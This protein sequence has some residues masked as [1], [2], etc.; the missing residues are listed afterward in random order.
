MT[1]RTAS[2]ERKKKET[3]IKLSLS[4]DGTG[5]SD[6]KTALVFDHMLVIS[7]MACLI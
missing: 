4:L 1:K 6:I 2:I 7:S 5:Q 3:D